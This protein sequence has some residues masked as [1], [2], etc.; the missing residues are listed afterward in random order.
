MHSNGRSF[1]VVRG[2][3][4]VGQPDPNVAASVAAAWA[5]G[6][7]HVDVYM[8]PVRTTNQSEWCNLLSVRCPAAVHAC[9]L[10]LFSRVCRCVVNGMC[11][12][13]DLW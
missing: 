8:F 11:A 3:E 2:W 5:G 10:I 6:M 13:P 9:S 7:A 12:V 4:S 1:A